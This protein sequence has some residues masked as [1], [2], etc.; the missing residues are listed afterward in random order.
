MILTGQL[1]PGDALQEAKLGELLDMSRTP[2]RE[3]IKSIEAEGLAERDGRFLRVRR[4][5]EEDVNEI[6][7]L[8]ET[9]EVHGTRMATALPPAT[10]DAM[11][12]RIHA[13]MQSGPGEGEEHWRVDEDFHLMLA[14]A[15]E[16]R[17]LVRALRD[18]RLRTCMFD[19]T[20]LPQRFLKG[21]EEHLAIIDALEN[22]DAP[23]AA[24]LMSG[25]IRN[26]RD[27]ILN[28]LSAYHDKDHAR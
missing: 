23:Q 20:R 5:S 17:T 19:H 15:A 3:A 11:K 14:G 7:L 13:L 8:R 28:R 24:A 1:L 9:L 27:A 10:L 6:F 16:N 18:L 4:L 26:A 12:S 22:G 21:C 2:V 25:H